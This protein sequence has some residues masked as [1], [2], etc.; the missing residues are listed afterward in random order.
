MTHPT[1]DYE[2]AL[3]RCAKGD[4]T[5]LRQIYETESRW[6]LGVAFRIV[7]DQQVA[8]DVV[9]EAFISIW[10]RAATFDP[11]RGSGRG[12]IYTIIRH[13]ALQ[14]IRG[15]G[16]KRRVETDDLEALMAHHADDGDDA[17]AGDIERLQSCLE[18]LEPER[19]R[20][21]EAAFVEGYTQQELAGLLGKP[22]GTIKSWIR[23]SL[24]ILRECLQ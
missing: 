22:L 19:R 2:A 18:R 16:S 20:C 4:R 1:F 12:W 9:Q 24:L 23:R 8:E 17:G 6:L 21:L 5:A 13:R 3:Q 11:T 14:E 7:R 10:T 15:P